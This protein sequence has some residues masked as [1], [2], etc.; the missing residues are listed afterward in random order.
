MVTQG[1]LT[2]YQGSS[3]QMM[4][5]AVLTRYE[6]TLGLRVQVQLFDLGA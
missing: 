6:R 1:V 4:S 5:Q 3:A 2:R